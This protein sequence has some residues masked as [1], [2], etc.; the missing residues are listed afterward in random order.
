MSRM[1]T[2]NGMIKLCKKQQEVITYGMESGDFHAEDVSIESNGT[3]F[4]LVDAADK[5]P[6]L[7]PA[8]GTRECL[9]SA[10]GFRCG[11]CAQR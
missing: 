10:G 7:E 1:S 6:D 8:A 5:Y 9:Q 11:L 4:T 3:K 2:V